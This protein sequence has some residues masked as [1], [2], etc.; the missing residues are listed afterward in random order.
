MTQ[1]LAI[2]LVELYN[3]KVSKPNYSVSSNFK[4][5][6]NTSKGD[7]MILVELEYAYFLAKASFPEVLAERLE[8]LK[9][10][11]APSDTFLK[12][13]TFGVVAPFAP[14]HLRSGETQIPDLLPFCLHTLEQ[15][16]DLAE[17]VFLMPMKC[18]MAPF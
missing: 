6:T 3:A 14:V 10:G 2:C 8:E 15:F 18:L 13:K 7:L 16:C 11:Q 9:D 5:P 12:D 17:E 4:K 1:E